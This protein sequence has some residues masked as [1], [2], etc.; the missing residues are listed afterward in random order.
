MTVEYWRFFRREFPLLAYGLSLTFLSSVGQTFL[1]SLFVPFFLR[2]FALSEA[3]FGVLYS[4][5]TLTSALLLPW[6]GQ[7]MDRTSLHHYT[8]AVVALLGLSAFLV[9]AA[10]H[11]VV[12]GVA[13]VGIRLAGQGLSSHT[14]LTTMARYYEAARGKALSISNLG[15]PLGEGILPLLLAGGIG[16]VGWRASWI[17]LGVAALLFA[18]LLVRLLRRSGVELDPRKVPKAGGRGA[19][20]AT[21]ASRS[22]SGPDGDWRRR[23][24]LRDSRFW[25]ALPAA[26]LPAFWITGLFLYQTSIAELRGWSL[27]LMASAFL[28]FA[29]TRVLF[30]L[31]A[32][33]GIDRLSARQLLPLTV[34]PMG[35][36][37]GLLWIG[38]APWVAY[39]FMALLGVTMGMSGA[40]QTA[41]WAELYGTRYLGAIKSML[42]SL[43]VV[44]T[45]ASPAIVG[46]VLERGRGLEGLLLGGVVSVAAGAV[47]ALGVLP[48]SAGRRSP[49]A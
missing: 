46:F 1:V 15:F 31:V 41:L 11:V 42:A 47:L 35:A 16:W 36:G 10:W 44:S 38:D 29:L 25:F 39:G 45:A 8:L 21:D 30:T 14:A 9:A 49:S 22:V 27:A 2:D 5:A 32:G 28:A 18:P 43:M 7:W 26:L 23:E 34:V 24:V 33:A 48:A 13:L 4:A 6:I 20:D 17:G 19:P 3:G 37:I 12:L 40:V